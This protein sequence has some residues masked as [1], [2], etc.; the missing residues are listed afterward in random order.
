MQTKLKQ[1]IAI[2][3]GTL[4]AAALPLGVDAGIMYKDSSNAFSV[5]FSGT[6][7]VD[8]DIDGDSTVD[9]R[10]EVDPFSSNYIDLNSVNPTGSVPGTFA[11]RGLVGP[12]GGAPLADSVSNLPMAFGVGPTLPAGASWLGYGLFANRTMLVGTDF[13]PT[14][15]VPDYFIGGEIGS[16]FIGF[17][18]LSGTDLV[19]GW[20]ELTLATTSGG[21]VTVNRWAY[22]D[23][24][25]GAICV[26]ETSGDVSA[27]EIPAPSTLAL[28]AAGAFGVRRW[29]T[30]RAAA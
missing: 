12:A 15:Y 28:L 13:F 19:Y 7:F 4:S 2:A 29:R 8:W 5:S 26:G 20:A 21:S 27:C 6:P 25:N 17:R 30:R 14:A 23:T 24:P 1:H 10:L 9:F 16:N 11:G 22:N 3:T 18:F